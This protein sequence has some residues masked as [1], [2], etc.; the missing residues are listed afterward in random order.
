M[1]L[2][3]CT[4]CGG[5]L[6][7]VFRFCPACGHSS[8]GDFGWPLE[9]APVSFSLEPEAPFPGEPEPTMSFP[10]V[11][12]PRRPRRE[13]R[14]TWWDRV[15]ARAAGVQYPAVAPAVRELGH[16]AAASSGPFVRK[17]TCRTARLARSSGEAIRLL[18]EVV[19]V[20][21][22]SAR[23]ALR[24]M[25]LVRKLQAQ[26]AAV[27][28]STGCAALSGDDR[29]IQHARTEL[30]ML[31]DL[32]TAATGHTSFPFRAG[33]AADMPTQETVRR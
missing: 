7:D 3:A 29:R 6:T 23:D 5:T 13:P 27:I 10:V 21:A 9:E 22:G 14:R 4:R 28:Y 11:E 16:R 17:A 32:I 24:S 8:E 2:R 18:L 19:L 30:R 33:T 1:T 31:D 12:R 20:C 25:V 15:V 26:R